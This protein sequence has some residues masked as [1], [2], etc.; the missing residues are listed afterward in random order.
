MPTTFA[1]VKLWLPPDASALQAGI[2]LLHSSGQ[3]SH[4]QTHLSLAISALPKGY[5]VD[6][7]LSA[8][9]WVN[10]LP[11]RSNP[12]DS[13]KQQ[14]PLGPRLL[15]VGLVTNLRG[16]VK[17]DNICVRELLVNSTA[18]ARLHPLSGKWQ[19]GYDAERTLTIEQVNVQQNMQKII[20]P[21]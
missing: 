15:V 17:T 8:T 18:A 6:E 16:W 12:N 9:Q 19:L 7:Y 21:S 11:Y 14:L 4:Y 1:Y 3:K 5:P 10:R 2:K 13:P 20:D